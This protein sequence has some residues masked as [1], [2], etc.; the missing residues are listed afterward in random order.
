MADPDPFIS[1]GTCYWAA[2]QVA[3][4]NFIPCGNWM[5]GHYHCCQVGDY[6]LA[7]NACFNGE[8]GT[9]YLAG[10]SDIEYD[11]FNCPDKDSYKGMVEI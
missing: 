11:I 6:C 7:H 8:H 9:T 3:S 10:C 1:N 4:D 5:L 2:N